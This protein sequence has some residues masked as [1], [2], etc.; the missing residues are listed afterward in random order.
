MLVFLNDLKEFFNRCCVRVRLVTVPF[1]VGALPKH[2]P[3]L[4][5]LVVGR[6][7]DGAFQ[8]FTLVAPMGSDVIY[9]DA[10]TS[11]TECKVNLGPEMRR[12]APLL[13]EFGDQL[14]ATLYFKL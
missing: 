10:L 14:L 2:F 1:L 13:D 5:A 11:D 6:F 9:L 3:I 12:R 8:R 4:F 7:R